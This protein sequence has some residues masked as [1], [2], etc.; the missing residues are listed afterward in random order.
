V[1]FNIKFNINLLLFSNDGECNCERNNF[2]LKLRKRHNY[3]TRITFYSHMRRNMSHNFLYYSLTISIY[4]FPKYLYQESLARYIC[5]QHSCKVGSIRMK[6]G[7]AWTAQERNF[8]CRYKWPIECKSVLRYIILIS[9]ITII[10]LGGNTATDAFISATCSLRC[11]LR[12][13][14]WW[15]SRFPSMSK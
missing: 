9:T 6:Q 10:T 13:S 7:V 2:L 3:T 4:I 5:V 15:H 8:L 1:K 14:A 11:F 12:R